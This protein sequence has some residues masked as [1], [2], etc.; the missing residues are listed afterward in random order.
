[1]LRPWKPWVCGS[2]DTPQARGVCGA[3][4]FRLRREVGARLTG[5]SERRGGRIWT[6]YPN[7]VHPK[8]DR[9]VVATLQATPQV[10]KD[11]TS[12]EDFVE[13]KAQ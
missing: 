6:K 10:L 9:G 12:V 7:K 11:L 1:M 5:R 3:R 2:S 8:L 13:V 4:R